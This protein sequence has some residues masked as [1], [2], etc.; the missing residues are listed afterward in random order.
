MS[1][2]IFFDTETGGIEPKHPTIQLAAIAI[3]DA[4]W[5]EQAVFQCKIRF[6]E[7]ACDP[8]ALKMNHYDPEVW[9]KE[10]VPKTAVA[11]RLTLFSKPYRSVQMISK[12]TGEPYSVAKLCGHNAL[13]FD[14]PRLREFYG[15]QFF[16]F[17]YHV[18]DTLQRA[19][20]YFDEHPLI[21]RPESLKLSVLCES[22]GIATDGAHDALTDVRLAISLAR[23]IK[24]NEQ[25]DIPQR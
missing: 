15:T 7:S 19:L 13:T 9:K 17:V 25:N 12:R 22:F 2:T 23:A 4:D 14:L 16:P 1:Y 21:K 5:S 11:S 3:D 6:D 10:A 18:K 24:E 20:W 8:E